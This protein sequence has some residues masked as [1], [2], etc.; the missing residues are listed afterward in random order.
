M[1]KKSSKKSIFIKA[2][3]FMVCAYLA[4]F[5]AGKVTFLLEKNGNLDDVVIGLKTLFIKSVPVGYVA[6]GVIS[7]VVLFVLFAGCKRKFRYVTTHEEDEEALDELEQQFNPP[8]IL[9]NTMMVVS[10]FFFICDLC[11]AEMTDYGSESLLEKGMLIAG[12]V[13]TVAVIIAVLVISHQM[14]EMEK[15]L[16]PEKQ[17]F[18]LDTNFEKVWL[19]SCDEAQK[20]MVYEASYTAFKNVSTACIV[21][22]VLSFPAIF[23]LHTGIYPS[24]VI[25]IIWLVNLLSYLLKAAKLEKVT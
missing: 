18:V 20:A 10:L 23:L 22:M 24:L 16:N 1:K 7:F 6:A 19:N 21:L 15:K 11:I 25:T 13:M 9:A 3:I 5:L 2:A 4:G 14:I 17:G 8:Y 12:G